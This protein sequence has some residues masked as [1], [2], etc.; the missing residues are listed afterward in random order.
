MRSNIFSESLLSA[1]FFDEIGG[2]KIKL[3]RLYTVLH[4]KILHAVY[5]NSLYTIVEEFEIYLSKNVEQY[6]CSI[7]IIHEQSEQNEQFKNFFQ[8]PCGVRRRTC[9]RA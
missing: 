1:F 7:I 3:Y 4:T 5:L 9:L 8:I 2:E 6:S